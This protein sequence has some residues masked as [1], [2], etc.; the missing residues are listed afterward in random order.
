VL[1]LLFLF[2]ELELN[3]LPLANRIYPFCLTRFVPLI[4][5][6]RGAGSDYVILHGCSMMLLELF[7]DAFECV[8]RQTPD[9]CHSQQIFTVR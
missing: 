8:G 2:A 3:S 6:L 4:E 7:V 9:C 5:A 1:D